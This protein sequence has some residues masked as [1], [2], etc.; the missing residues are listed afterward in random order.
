MPKL[1]TIVARTR[2]RLAV[3]AALLLRVVV[4]LAPAL[5][6]IL[7]C[8]GFAAARRLP[9]LNG[10]ASNSFAVFS[11]E[12]GPAVQRRWALVMNSNSGR[13]PH[14]SSVKPTRPVPAKEPG[15]NRQDGSC[16]DG[17]KCSGPQQSSCRPQKL[18]DPRVRPSSLVERM[19]DR[20]KT[21]KEVVGQPAMKRAH[22]RC[23]SRPHL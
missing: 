5:L 15:P 1:A 17:H 19:A 9:R 4:V 10:T 8:F 2:L 11:C 7:F 6:R 3:L 22:M 20:M 23:R 21:A 13:M 14:M 16:G 12:V 18:E